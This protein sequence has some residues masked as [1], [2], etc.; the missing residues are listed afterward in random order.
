MPQNHSSRTNSH[1]DVLY[2]V[3]REFNAG[4]DQDID[5]VLFNV[6]SATVASVGATEACLFLFDEPD[7]VEQALIISNSERKEYPAE[8]V[9]AVVQHGLAGWVWQNKQG[10]VINNT[11]SDKRWYKNP[12]T[13][14]IKNA[15]SALGVPVQTAP[16]HPLGVLIITATEAD[17][18]NKDD[19]AMLTVIAGQAA[20]AV[21]NTR[22]YRAE[23]HR[24]RV[25]DVLGSIAHTI[26]STLNLDEVLHL[27]LE[28]LARVISYDSSSILL[29]NPETRELAV[30]AARGFE[31]MQD[32]LNVR[33]SFDRNSPNYQAI[34]NKAPVLI[35]N[36]DEEPNWKKSPSSKNVKS[37]IGAPLIARNEVVGILTVDSYQLHQ[38]GQDN[39]DVVA[40][41]A[42]QAAT[43]VAN[44][45]AVSRLQMAEASYSALFEDSTD[46]IL[47]TDYDG[48]IL[49]VNRK[50]CQILRRPKDAITGLNITFFSPQLKEFLDENTA[51]LQAW[52][53]A[54]IDVEIVDAYR[55]KIPLDVRM[56]HIQFGGFERVEWVG[57][58]IS[59]RKE[60]ER[61][62]QDLV[63][64]LVHDL[65]GPLGNLINTIDLMIMMVNM[66]AE[67][68]KLL[69]FLEMGK[70]TGR[71]LTDL[72]DSMLDVSRLEQGEVPLQCD[73]T[74]LAEFMQEVNEQVELQANGK[75]TT[76]IYAPLPENVKE[77]WVDNSLIRRV[78]TN[79]IG[80]AIKYAPEKSTVWIATEAD[81][82]R[83]HFSVKDNGPGIPKA[84][85]PRIFDK[86]S[87]VNY[88]ADGPSGVGLG[89]AFCKL[90]VEAHGGT[91]SVESEGVP[92]QGSTFH[93]FLPRNVGC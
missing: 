28:Q 14:Q 70:R 85:Q 21:S 38:Y 93:V 10:A 67:G 51:L 24:R 60:I 19:L 62:R 7:K 56:R 9:D 22:L 37:W 83:I 75:E 34:L 81:E 91:I 54:S 53:E 49:N 73:V 87:R 1:L 74:N 17:F 59:R 3:T 25:A 64:M 42:D 2:L 32:A 35:G 63:N 55:Q 5:D 44:A 26:N 29:Y 13:P 82:G 65:R 69:Q 39:V 6:L 47:I 84:E 36:V 43:A 90:A 30:T 15:L 40:A 23:M 45:Q 89:L 77:I 68:E 92:G 76:L 86:F 31:D 80:N 20:F 41:F 72:V 12:P 4:L 50:G 88:S 52:R 66:G 33:L 78:L 48:V 18:F 57:R 46:M 71:T 27:I 16:D 58:D 79:L 11:Q 61:M 8:I